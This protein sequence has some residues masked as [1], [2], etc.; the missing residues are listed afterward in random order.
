L[1]SR[2]SGHAIAEA[3]TDIMNT[4]QERMIELRANLLRTI[5]EVAVAAADEKK[6]QVYQPT[7]WPFTM[8]EYGTG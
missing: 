3:A 5:G 4:I 6:S 2:Y 1:D 8:M 7:V